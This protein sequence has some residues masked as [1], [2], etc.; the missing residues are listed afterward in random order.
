MLLPL[1]RNSSSHDTV[2][3]VP[4]STG[5]VSSVLKFLQ[6]GFRPVH[7]TEIRFIALR[8]MML[9]KIMAKLVK[10]FLVEVFIPSLLDLSSLSH[11]LTNYSDELK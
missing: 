9:W 8:R 5:N 7:I 6:A 4:V 10:Y 11:E 2:S 1:S 3:S